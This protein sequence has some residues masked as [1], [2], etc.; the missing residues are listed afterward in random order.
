MV[1]KVEPTICVECGFYK[2]NGHNHD[3]IQFSNRFTIKKCEKHKTLN[4]NAISLQRVEGYNDSDKFINIY[5][6][7]FM[8]YICKALPN[9]MA[10]CNNCNIIVCLDCP[11][12]HTNKRLA[13]ICSNKALCPNCLVPWIL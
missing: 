12:Y 5:F 3:L 6:N 10:S 9:Q 2:L 8:C 1:N 13:N 4:M 11:V 7:A